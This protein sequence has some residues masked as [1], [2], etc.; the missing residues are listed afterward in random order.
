MTR[1]PVVVASKA[2][3]A[4]APRDCRARAAGICRRRAR[5]SF[6][7]Q[8]SPGTLD[9]SVEFDVLA[10]AMIRR[11]EGVMLRGVYRQESFL[12]ERAF[13]TSRAAASAIPEAATKH[14][15]RQ[16]LNPQPLPPVTWGALRA[17][18]LSP[19]EAR[20]LNPQPLPPKEAAVNRTE[21]LNPLESR[22]LN[23]QPLPPRTL[24]QI[25][26]N[27]LLSHSIFR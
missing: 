3:C 23:P 22:G 27:I 11:K 2:R 24:S 8:L 20:G 17:H 18:L 16:G 9:K 19:L 25:P 6:R 5:L 7:R 13:T 26:T 10:V 14:L 4:A 21:W 1:T 15:V 12:T